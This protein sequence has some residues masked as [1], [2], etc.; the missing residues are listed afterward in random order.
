MI[1]RTLTIAGNPN[2]QITLYFESRSN[3]EKQP[4]IT[5]EGVYVFNDDFKQHVAIADGSHIIADLITDANA[6]FDATGKMEVAKMKG[7]HRLDQLIQSDPLL[8]VWM[9]QKQREHR[10]K[11]AMQ[12]LV[13]A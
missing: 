6:M 8:K 13:Q 4:L 5:T 3:A 11:Q 2:T 12:G 1:T 7:A 9:E 10:Q